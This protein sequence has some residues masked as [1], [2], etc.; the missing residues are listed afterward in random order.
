M[1][2]RL[3]LDLT[4][5]CQVAVG[6]F[7][8]IQRVEYELGA[9]LLADESLDVAGIVFDRAAGVF[10]DADAREIYAR[11]STVAPVEPIPCAPAD[12]PHDPQVGDPQGAPLTPP[13]AG[14][15]QP[16]HVP[17]SLTRRLLH[18]FTRTRAY[19][20]LRDRW[21]LA[22]IRRAVRPAAPLP[23]P[24]EIIAE[25][26]QVEPPLTAPAQ[27]ASGD[28]LLM[29]G[30]PWVAP[31]MST[32]LRKLKDH[33]G[34]RVVL[35]VH[36]LIPVL[37]PEVAPIDASRF[38]E[39]MTQALGVVDLCIAVS[40]ATA[41][42]IAQVC[43]R[44]GLPT[45]PVNVIRLGDDLAGQPQPDRP[46]GIPEDLAP[47]VLV[48]GTVEVR[49]NH[50]VLYQA[51]QQA[52]LDG[53]QLPPL[54]IVGRN[55]WLT[56]DL[57]YQLEHSPQV[58]GRIIHLNSVSDAELVW[59]YT[60]CLFTVFPSRYEGWGLPVAEALA[61]HKFC[62]ASDA[63]SIPEIGG[64]LLD[65]ASPY[66]PRGWMDKIAHYANNLDALAEHVASIKS[67]YVATTW[68][69]TY[70]ALRSSL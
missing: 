11:H 27:V 55:G 45:P 30:A 48:V 34:C 29:L 21:P 26:P 19:L 22:A 50:I 67:G 47:F 17:E 15:G 23:V 39:F 52:L 18:R 40:Q 9:R 53:V 33:S 62:I 2:A 10:V 41:R 6:G 65:Y 24:P 1:G 12:G 31:D 28:T 36:D 14:N 20:A 51:Y 58:G 44:E 5:F 42:D 64:S 43:A 35:L 37:H 7:S 70:S 32:E 66:D 46:T 54:L 69:A 25:P 38:S 49:K 68:D 60:N 59:A 4:E 63:S 3:L 57:R 56:D 61:R 16:V 8:G 13:E